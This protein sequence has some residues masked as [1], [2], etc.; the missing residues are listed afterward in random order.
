M[1]PLSEKGNTKPVFAARGVVMQH[2]KIIGKNKNVQKQQQSMRRET[3]WKPSVFMM[4]RNLQN[5]VKEI[6]VKCP[7]HFTL[8]S[9]N[10]GEKEQIQIVITHYR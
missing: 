1:E 2:V 4:H 9:M 6:T 3:G 7:L 5:G 10:S 8:E